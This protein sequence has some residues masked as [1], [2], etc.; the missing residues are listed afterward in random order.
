[1][2]CP[3]VYDIL[4]EQNITASDTI[5]REDFSKICPGLY[6]L[7][8]EKNDADHEDDH[9]NEPPKSK[10]S[11]SQGNFPVTTPPPGHPCWPPLLATLLDHP[12]W[13]SL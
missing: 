2:Q 11:S 4:V 1:M 13:T 7:F 8:V 6:A 12:S 3:K 5:K 9:P 10:I